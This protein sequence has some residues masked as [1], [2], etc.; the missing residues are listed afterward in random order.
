[1]RVECH[2]SLVELATAKGFA[3]FGG[4][5][6]WALDENQ[7]VSKPRCYIWFRYW[8]DMCVGWLLHESKPRYC[9]YGVASNTE[10]S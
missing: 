1:M 7:L 6:V 4:C 9:S 8:L 5:D 10:F 3:F 2:S